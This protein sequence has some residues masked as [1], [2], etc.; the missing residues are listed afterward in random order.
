MIWRLLFLAILVAIII[1]WAAWPGI[2]V[3]LA[4]RRRKR[5]ECNLQQR[6]WLS[7]GDGT[8]MAETR[9]LAGCGYHDK[10]HVHMNPEDFETWPSDGW[11]KVN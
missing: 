5:H 11:E 10:G 1:G 6:R 4:R 7:E 2:E 3:E 8:P 9:C